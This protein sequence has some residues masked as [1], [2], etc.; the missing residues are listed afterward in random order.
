MTESSKKRFD[1]LIEGLKSSD[2]EVK[3]MSISALGILKIKNHSDELHDLLSSPDQEVIIATIKSLGLIANP[4]SVKYLIDFISNSNAKIANEAFES[5]KRIDL[6]SVEDIMIRACSAD[7]PVPLRKRIVE[8]LSSYNDVRV[9]SLMN[10][11]L[12]QTRDPEFLTLAISYFIKYPSAERHTSLKMLSGNGNWSISLYA[13]LALSRLKD[14]GAFIQIKRLAKSSNSEIRQ[15]IVDS[16]NSYQLIEDRDIYK[17]LFNDAR[18]SIRKAALEGLSLF[19]ADERIKII[20]QQIN[21]EKEKDIRILLLQKAAHEKS[22]LLFDDLFRLLKSTDEELQKAT[23]KAL[24]EIGEKIVDRIIV[25]YDRMPLLMKE[26]LLLVLGHI[27]SK[28]ASYLVKEALHAK[29]RWIKINAIEASVNI[30]SKELIDSIKSIIKSPNT[31]IW[32]MAT[33]IS[34]LGRLNDPSLVDFL[35]PNLKNKDARVRANTIEALSSYKWEGLPE[36]CL[37]LLKDRNDRVRVNAAIALWKSG[38]SEVFEELEKM[39]RDRSRWVRSSAVF[40]LGQINDSAGI[41]I[42][43]RM[44]HDSEDMVYRN[45]LEAL[46]WHGDLRSLIPLLNEAHKGRLRQE[47]YESILDRFAQSIKE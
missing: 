16:I 11:I 34:A 4:S 42:L 14:E 23:I 13:N 32:V 8:L 30:K 46:S 17:I 18:S 47:F 38:H 44:L 28:K 20:Q 43:I 37:Q 7:Q 22:S 6:S 26:Q 5:L 15:I 2:R 3:L 45:V 29:E 10:E 41:P 36:A 39:S 40:A 25:D 24:G 33:A 12:G 35:I 1:K 9:S 31:D 21:L 19:A 27:G